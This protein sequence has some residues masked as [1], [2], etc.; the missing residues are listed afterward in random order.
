MTEFFLIRHAQASFGCDDY[1]RLSELGRKQSR[2]LGHY[3]E[4]RGIRFDQL[5]TGSQRRHRQTAELALAGRKVPSSQFDA[6]NE[7]HFQDLCKAYVEQFPE[8]RP[9]DDTGQSFFKVLRK[10]LLAWSEERLD[11]DTIPETWE[12]FQSRIAAAQALLTRDQ[13]LERVLVISSGGPISQLIGRFLEL[14]VEKTIDL[15]MQIC[16]TSI[17]RGFFNGS[18]QMLTAFNHVPHLDHPDRAQSITFS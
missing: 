11:S 17:S 15:N 9:D 6:F 8:E 1:D 18:K 16:N 7:Y 2:W 5:I 12:Q 14:S 10:T 4:E 3:F 13:Q